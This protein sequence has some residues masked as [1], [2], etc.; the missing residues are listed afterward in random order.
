MTKLRASKPGD[1]AK[2][3]LMRG[4]Q[5]MEIDVKLKASTAARRPQND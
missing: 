1:V 3:K 5:A 4:T 2:I